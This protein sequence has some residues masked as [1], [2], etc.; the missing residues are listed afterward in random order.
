MDTIDNELDI[1]VFPSLYLA[2]RGGAVAVCRETDTSKM[3]RELGFVPE[4][5]LEREARETAECHGK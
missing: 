3:Q 5:N 2:C 4:F 1:G